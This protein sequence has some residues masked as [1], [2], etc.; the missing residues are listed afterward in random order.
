MHPSQAPGS[1]SRRSP[2]AEPMPTF[3]A[4]RTRRFSFNGTGNGHAPSLDL[5]PS[6]NL[7]R[8]PSDI[9]R[10]AAASPIVPRPRRLSSAAFQTPSTQPASAPAARAPSGSAVAERGEELCRRCQVRRVACVRTA[11]CKRHSGHDPRGRG[12]CPAFQGLIITHGSQA[13]TAILTAARV[14]SVH[15]C[16]FIFGRSVGTD[17]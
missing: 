2:P 5:Q 1:R 7:R 15:H 11:M 6:S 9:Y 8:P 10:G 12:F 16:E 3:D 14:A 4:T 13:P 17:L